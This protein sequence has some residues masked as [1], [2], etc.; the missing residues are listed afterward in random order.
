VSATAG[1]RLDDVFAHVDAN[2]A[3]FV[4]RLAGWVR[5]PSV[6]AT[7]QGMPEAAG[8][9]RDL[10]AA[11]GLEATVAGTA[12]WPLVLGHRAGPP[13]APTV[14]V[15]GHYDVQPPDP[16]DAWAS[17]PFE[18][19]VRDGRLYGRGG[20]DNKGQHL[21]Q[22]LAVES[23]LAT[24]GELPCTVKVL[25]D[26][27]EEI[28]SP[29]LAGFA[30]A[31]RELL[32]ADL[33]VWSDGPVDPG[34]GWRLV[35]G[36]RG[37]ASFELRARGANRSL[38]SGNWGGVAPNPLWTLVHLLATMRDAQGRIT[39]DGFGDEVEPLGPAE[40]AALDRLP[41]DVEAVK[42]DLGL[43]R[44]DAPVE[45]GFAERLAAWPTLTINGLHGG[46]G[47]QGTQTVLP[48]EAVAKCDVRLVHA[49]RAGDVYDKLEAHVR[50]HAPGVELVRQGSM[51]PSRT[52]MD[53]AW[54][55]PI[56]AAMAA[57][58]GA[59][60]LLVPVLGGSLPLHV[61]TG[62]LGLPTFGIPLGNPDQANHAP[63][64]NLDLERF[65]TGIKTAAAV[66]AKLGLSQGSASGTIAR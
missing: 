21:A 32:A 13:G 47:G 23:L 15:Y 18:P 38:H 65:H 37:I 50:R 16:L 44:L 33:V 5:T 11:A 8:H 28:G 17:P 60:P 7:G 45:R 64:E 2:R 46:Y 42:A 36:V 14:L 26:G 59:E 35:F 9:A 43:E 19:E 49:Q 29:H 30:A 54:T 1:P 31:E 6:S 24:R 58:Q 39:V 66:L 34:G 57:A 22:L 55:A 52:P 56:R 10:V 25:L 20:A 48:A 4:E 27:E 61:F 40:R 62:V 63:N 12:G 53:S 41:V 51:E 3:S